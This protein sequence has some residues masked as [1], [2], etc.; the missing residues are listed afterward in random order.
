MVTQA[1]TAGLRQF[2][3]ELQDEDD[4]HVSPRLFSKQLRLSNGELASLAHVHY[5]TVR[6]FPHSAQ[7]QKYLR[8]AVQVLA[9]ASELAGDDRLRAI[10]W[11]RNDPI[12]PLGYKTAETLVSEGHTEQVLRY[13]DTLY[14]GTG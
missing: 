1:N 3:A 7:L 2:L 6:H 11:F 13:V 9:A 4:V 10:Y 12:G 8:D 5:S 14:A